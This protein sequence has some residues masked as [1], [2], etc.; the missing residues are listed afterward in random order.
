MIVGGVGLP[1]N[2]LSLKRCNIEE[3]LNMFMFFLYTEE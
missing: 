3:L 2:P 1:S